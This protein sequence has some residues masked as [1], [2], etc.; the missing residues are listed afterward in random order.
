[1]SL[2]IG[3]GARASWLVSLV[4]GTVC[5][6]CF[7]LGA[8]AQT[9]PAA[10]A[11]ASEGASP[12]AGPPRIPVE[13]Y[14]GTRVP[15]HRVF[16]PPPP[17]PGS[18]AAASDAAIFSA[19]RALENGPR[20]QLAAS[21]DR[22]GQKALLGDFSCAVG[23]DLAGASAPALSRLLAR[24]GADAAAVFTSAK[25]TYRR[26][27]PF[28]AETPAPI[29]VTPSEAFAKSGSYPSG[30]ATV[31]WLYALVLAELDPERAAGIAARGRAYGESR[32]VCGVH[33][34]SDVE[35]GRLTAA[36]VV[37]A[38]HGT[39]EFEADVAAARAE[40]AALRDAGGAARAAGACENEAAS[41]ATPW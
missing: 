10:S 19:T 28:L 9:A 1:M 11:N 41:L 22:V 26:P 12:S 20:W 3:A 37:A 36:T 40:L 31:G 4:L 6:A 17:A 35:A 13:G 33:Y 7:Q 16:L 38:L 39:P 34:V 32:V 2:T 30:H 8:E 5:A 29:C 25:D 24:S 14:L 27:R 21:D 15:D 18:P 23:L